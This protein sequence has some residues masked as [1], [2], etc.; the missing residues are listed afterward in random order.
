MVVIF[1][2]FAGSESAS[3]VNFLFIVNQVK[4]FRAVEMC[5]TVFDYKF[6]YKYRNALAKKLLPFFQIITIW[7]SSQTPFPRELI[8]RCPT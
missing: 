2:F 7:S 3:E 1:S 5:G 6:D 8:C 4:E